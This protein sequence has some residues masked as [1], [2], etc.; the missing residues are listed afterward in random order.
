M[1]PGRSKRARVRA[2]LGVAIAGLAFS[3][4]QAS[5]L[6]NHYTC[7]GADCPG[8]NIDFTATT[9]T[10]YPN[11]PTNLTLRYDEADQQ[12][13]AMSATYYIPK[14]WAFSV[15]Q[16]KPGQKADGSPAATCADLFTGSAP[17]SIGKA[18]ALSA[19]ESMTVQVS[20]NRQMKTGF[21]PVDTEAFTDSAPFVYGGVRT[22]KP[23]LAFLSYD[24]TTGVAKLCEYL[25]NSSM[26]AGAQ[27][28][29]LPVTLARVSSTD[30][31][32]GWTASFDLTPMYK[33]S[34]W[35]QDQASV[36]AHTL[37]FSATTA[38]NWTTDPT[39]GAKTSVVESA[40]PSTPGNYDFRAVF[41][42]CAQGLDPA[43]STGCRA[44][45]T[46]SVTK[47]V[48]LTITLPPAP[49]VHDFGRLTGP[50]SAGMPA[51][52]AL[53]VG[54]STVTAKWTQPAV[55][56]NDSIK[57]YV[58]TV[59]IPGKQETRHF[60]YMVT[61]P[62]LGTFDARTQ[63]GADGKATTC[64]LDLTF[65][66]NTIGTGKLN[67]NDKYA[68]SLI[69]IYNG[70]HRT[71]G[72]CD[73]GSDAGVTCSPN[74]PGFRVVAPGI[75][76]WQFLIT[77]DAWTDKFVQTASYTPTGSKAPA[78]T[79]P[80]YMLLVNFTQ[81][82]AAFIE[83]NINGPMTTFAAA[84]NELVGVDQVGGAVA[85]AS[86]TVAGPGPSWQFAGEADT[87]ESYGVFNYYDLHN[88]GAAPTLVTL[89]FQGTRIV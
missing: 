10:N 11:S 86:A 49:G 35:V 79:A 2:I 54:T 23:S 46:T 33:N 83:W 15:D 36:L 40:T 45:A 24:A 12:M 72:L 21:T 28:V 56:P 73:D 77:S 81:K 42:I 87:Q 34:V 55:G 29:I 67:G 47:D 50:T 39:T 61:D 4:M 44:D 6:A 8:A 80:A 30:P 9:E 3:A 59:A 57:G 19:G 13:P 75:S 14:G 37:G 18:E 89:P 82:R 70:G 26:G 48:P 63:C 31:S 7:T 60:E 25:Y 84:S 85:F 53:A 68:L 52:S 41:S 17:R 74:Q 5:A 22:N 32:F 71:D 64:Q 76:R 51:G 78:F 20:G 38:G 27:E 1:T 66:L 65:P 16:L 62:S 69:T 58:L 88:F 43:S